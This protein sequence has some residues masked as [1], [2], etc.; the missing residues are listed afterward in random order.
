MNNTQ[1]SPG[2]KKGANKTLKYNRKKK[3]ESIF[4]SQTRRSEALFQVLRLE[5]FY[6][7]KCFNIT[8]THNEKFEGD[9]LKRDLWV[10][11]IEILG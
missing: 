2:G 10:F 9:R 6:S 3:S 1:E 4:F 8:K 5:I 11:S 7:M